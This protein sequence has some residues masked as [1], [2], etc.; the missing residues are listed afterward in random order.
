MRIESTSVA[1]LPCSQYQPTEIA[2]KIDQLCAAIGFK[3]SGG[4]RVLLKPNLLTGRSPGHLAC[5]H[6]AFVAAVAEWFMDQ[7]AKVAIGDSPAFGTAKGVMHAAGID[8]ALAGLSVERLNFDQSTTVR[9]AG[10]VK[11]EMARAA[12]ECDVL[13]NLPRVKAHSQLFVTL[14]VKNYFGT[15][16]GFQKPWWHLRYGNHAEQFASHLLDLLPVLP[17]GVS[18][19]DGIV[20]MHGTGPISGLPYSLGLVAG[21]VNPVALDTALLQVLG[22]DMAQ[23]ALWLEC[24]KRGLAGAEPDMLNYPLLKPEECSVKDF[25]APA[26][27]KPVSFNP[28]RMLVSACRRF[29]ARVKESS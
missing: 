20:A 8:K 25:T 22:L 16:V 11:V 26:I 15:V 10:G 4:A 6:P 18:L 29:A 1:L 27:L 19:L 21:A 23:S 13:V 9:L 2:E 12:L 28:M 17:S 7:G 14:A 24:I 5:T 3:V